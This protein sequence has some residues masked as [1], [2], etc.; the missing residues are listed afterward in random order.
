MDYGEF[1]VDLPMGLDWWTRKNIVRMQIDNQ[2]FTTNDIHRAEIISNCMD[3]VDILR[4][5][6]IFTKHFNNYHYKYTFHLSYKYTQT[7]KM[8]TPE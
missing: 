7:G 5:G 6:I 8:C 4:E 2:L 1:I 3:T